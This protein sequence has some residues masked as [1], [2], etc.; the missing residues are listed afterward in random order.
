M[1]T[2]TTEL[3]KILLST[4]AR[5]RSQEIRVCCRKGI[6]ENSNIIRHYNLLPPNKYIHPP[7]SPYKY[8]KNDDVI[9]NVCS[10]LSHFHS[11]QRQLRNMCTSGGGLWEPR[12]NLY[13]FKDFNGICQHVK[14]VDL[15]SSHKI[16]FEV[17]LYVLL[18]WLKFKDFSSHPQAIS[19]PG[20]CS[21]WISSRLISFL[22]TA[23]L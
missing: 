23:T 8:L 12:T 13:Q 11:H 21:F 1:P 7:S 3:R 15:L 2:T 18:I 10:L 5:L 14:F 6:P 9:H 17:D 4:F 22:F 16:G 19:L 20:F